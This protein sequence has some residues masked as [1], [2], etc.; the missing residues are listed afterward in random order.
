M[1]GASYGNRTRALSLE[2]SNSTIKLNSLSII[3]YAAI[4]MTSLSLSAA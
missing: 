4:A 3:Y 1:F 2:G